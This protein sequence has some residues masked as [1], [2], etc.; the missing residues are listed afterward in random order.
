MLNALAGA[1]GP[2][3]KKEAPEG[4]S[5]PHCG[6]PMAAQQAT[7]PTGMSDDD[8]KQSIGKRIGYPGF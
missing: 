4:D 1:F 3:P 6:Q 7:G 5:C 2:K 8:S